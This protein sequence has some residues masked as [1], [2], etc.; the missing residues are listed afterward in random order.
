MLRPLTIYPQ[1]RNFRTSMAL[2]K[3]K[4]SGNEDLYDLLGV[5]KAASGK[6]IKRAFLLKAKQYHPDVN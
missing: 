2:L 4:K 3:A 1:L 6:E 5:T